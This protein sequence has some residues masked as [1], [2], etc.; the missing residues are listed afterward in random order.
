MA[1]DVTVLTPAHTSSSSGGG[2]VAAVSVTVV[3]ERVVVVELVCCTSSSIGRV[4]LVTL[5]EDAVEGHARARL[6]Q[7]QQ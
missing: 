7:N 5:K 4:V 6:L 2:G 3:T 1:T